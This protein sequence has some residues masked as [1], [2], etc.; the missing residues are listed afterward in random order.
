M[1]NNNVKQTKT[2][3][4]KVLK[5]SNPNCAVLSEQEINNLFLG[6]VRLI[7]K[8]VVVEKEKQLKSEVNY[9]NKRIVECMNVIDKKNQEIE[10][11]KQEISKLINAAN[12][13]ES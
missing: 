1:E 6:F 9:C 4:D 5:F 7:K 2:K 10:N 3:P 13:V 8:S 12:K 11:L